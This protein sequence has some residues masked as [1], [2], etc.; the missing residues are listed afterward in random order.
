M[1][2]LYRILLKDA[3]ILKEIARK[4]RC[5][6][7]QQERDKR[8]VNSESSF[9]TQNHDQPFLEKFVKKEFL[10]LF[11]LFEK[12]GLQIIL[13]EIVHRRIEYLFQIL[14][15]VCQVSKLLVF[16]PAVDNTFISCIVF[17]IFKC[18]YFLVF[19]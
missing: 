1:F 7:L 5:N 3:D 12:R 18:S 9:V 8:E 16:L 14:E 10:F 17:F 4:C 13:N 2:S 15:T 19:S 6:T 11:S